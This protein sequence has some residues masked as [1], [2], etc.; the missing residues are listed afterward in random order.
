MSTMEERAARRAR[1][2]EL[3]EKS[4]TASTPGSSK[5]T[6]GSTRRPPTKSATATSTPG[7]KPTSSATSSTTPGRKPTTTPGRTAP[8]NTASSQQAAILRQRSA[9]QARRQAAG[10]PG[11]LTATAA[12]KKEAKALQATI[13]DLTAQNEALAKEIAELTEAHEVV[14]NEL[15]L[16]S[17]ALRNLQEVHDK[18]QAQSET[19]ATTTTGALTSYQAAVEEHRLKFSSATAELTAAMQTALALSQELTQV[20]SDVAALRKENKALL[21]AADDNGSAADTSGAELVQTLDELQAAQEQVTQA[22]QELDAVSARHADLSAELSVTREHLDRH[23]AHVRDEAAKAASADTTSTVE[24]QQARSLIDTL[25]EQLDGARTQQS[26]AEAAAA[27][28]R[29]EQAERKLL[30]E[31]RVDDLKRLTAEKEAVDTRV[32]S[33]ASSSES[34]HSDLQHAKTQAAEYEERIAAYATV[35]SELAEHR[36]RQKVSDSLQQQLETELSGMKEECSALRTSALEAKQAITDALRG[37][38]AAVQEKNKIATELAA[39]KTELLTRTNASTA[40]DPSD[41]QQQISAITVENAD[42]AARVAAQ[43]QKIADLEQRL[44]AQDTARQQKLATDEEEKQRARAEALKAEQETAA[45]RARD[46]E[47]ADR[48]RAEDEARRKLLEQEAE[49]QRVAEARQRQEREDADRKEQELAAAEA[50]RNK[51]KQREADEERARMEEEARKR[52]LAAVEKK[53]TP[54]KTDADAARRELEAQA[55]AQHDGGLS[56]FQRVFQRRA[57]RRG[58]RPPTLPVEA[59]PSPVPESPGPTESVVP[60]VTLSPVKPPTPAATGGDDSGLNEFQRVLQR[61]TSLRKTKPPGPMPS[62]PSAS[63]AD[64]SGTDQEPA[65]EMRNSPKSA[66]ERA[67]MWEKRLS[68]PQAGTADTAP[69]EPAKPLGRK[70][71]IK[72]WKPPQNDKCTFCDKTVYAME[73]ILADGDCFHKACFRCSSC[74][75]MLSLG[76]YAALDGKLYCKP[77]FKKLFK[78]KG[79]YSQGF[80]KE[81]HKM[82]WLAK[83]AEDSQA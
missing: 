60:A 8:R 32:A 74:N 3:S 35:E 65:V 27:T 81:Q 83:Q 72:G 33:S 15:L 61:R 70:A 77:C 34:L 28:L 1:L 2:K 63:G 20:K 76:N 6:T 80:G 16:T 75:K 50:E 46:A 21:A 62:D 39:A 67:S 7:R 51:V 49:L 41:V 45:Q 59:V 71:S 18:L 19:Q 17:S 73:K 58:G 56:E 23:S 69:A 52:A 9:T 79:N 55:A 30:Y 25:R 44:Q 54:S 24:L 14:T 66:A 36:N 26:S 38:L 4:S 47:A 13:N 42:N 48:Q 57:S 40:G 11:S 22:T 37:K 53:E 68:M 10:G 78:L 82:K 64:G 12:A 43:R 5:R 29:I 31:G